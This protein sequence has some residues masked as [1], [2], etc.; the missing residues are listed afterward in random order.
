MSLENEFLCPYLHVWNSIVPTSEG[1]S[2]R[3]RDY[4]EE[5]GARAWEQSAVLRQGAAP[6]DCLTGVS[7]WDKNILSI[8]LLTGLQANKGEWP[9]LACSETSPTS[10]PESLLELHDMKLEV[11]HLYDL[12]YFKNVVLIFPQYEQY[13]RYCFI[14]YLSPEVQKVPSSD[15][16]MKVW[17]W[18]SLRRFPSSCRSFSEVRPEK[19]YGSIKSIRLWSR[20]RRIK[21]TRPSNSPGFTDVSLL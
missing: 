12:G 13:L 2:H 20:W 3:S 16:V 7:V 11:Q 9:I 18:M 4:H 15:T 10:K 17:G 8:S 6:T 19:E 14:S 21:P 5:R 1:D